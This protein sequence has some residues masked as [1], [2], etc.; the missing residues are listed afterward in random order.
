MHIYIHIHTYIKSQ[1]PSVLVYYIFI[2]IA[3]LHMRASELVSVILET[4]GEG[5]W[6]ERWLHY[7]NHL[8]LSCELLWPMNTNSI[9]E[10]VR[11]GG[12]VFGL[13]Q[14]CCSLVTYECHLPPL[15]AAYMMM[16]MMMSML[17]AGELLAGCP[18]CLHF[19]CA[20]ERDV[21]PLPTSVQ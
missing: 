12:G 4:Q 9:N 1:R 8:M 2:T 15:P 6:L 7:T 21:N 13:A 18:L 5:H 14:C 20:W 10:G 17:F 3:E 16:M 11:G 19:T